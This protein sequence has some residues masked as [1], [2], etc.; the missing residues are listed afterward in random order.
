MDIYIYWVYIYIMD[1]YIHII[2]C[3]GYHRILIID[4]TAFHNTLQRE[5]NLDHGTLTCGAISPY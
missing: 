5:A 2:V 1:I 3:D 4:M